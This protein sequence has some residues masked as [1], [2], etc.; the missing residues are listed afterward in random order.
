MNN[1]SNQKKDFRQQSLTRL[2]LL[3]AIFVTSISQS[4]AQSNMTLY[5]L[6]EKVLSIVKSDKPE[7]ILDYV[8]TGENLD[9]KADILASFISTK[10]TLENSTD[11]NK[12]NL[13]NVVKESDSIVYFIMK[14]EKKFFVIKSTLDETNKI[15]DSFSLLKTELARKIE[16][17]ELVY[18]ARC[19][20]CH[21][22]K[23]KGG[24]LG[25]NLTDEYCKFSVKSDADL[26]DIIANGKK[27]TMMIAFK[28]Y[29]TPEEIKDVSIYLKA[30]KG[31]KVKNAKPKEGNSKS[32]NLKLFN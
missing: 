6:G 31:I 29:L 21:G 10:T 9:K 12:L 32:P 24:L 30:L 13:F 20:S 2:A 23:G 18:K 4:N 17:G 15:T 26:I 19:Y 11:I 16:K 1:I 25:P 7:T 27:G 14:N 28:D 8:N 5:N 22:L 3:L